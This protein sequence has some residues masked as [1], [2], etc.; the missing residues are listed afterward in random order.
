MVRLENFRNNNEELPV[1]QMYWTLESERQPDKET[2]EAYFSNW[3]T[4]NYLVDDD[5][6]PVPED[7]PPSKM[8]FN[9]TKLIAWAR[10]AEYVE[11][12]C[13]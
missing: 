11:V 9:E 4:F 6:L 8:Y 10:A 13:A 5:W 2:V 1:Q 7:V 12:Q 3:F